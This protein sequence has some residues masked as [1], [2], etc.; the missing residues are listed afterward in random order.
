LLLSD[1]ASAGSVAEARHDWGLCQPIYIQYGRF[2]ANII[3]GDLGMSFKYADPVI[4]LIGERLP[5]PIELAIASML[6]ALLAGIPLGV[7]A[8]AK[9]KSWADNFGSTFGFFGRSMPSCW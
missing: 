2:L 7:W 9:P 3:S 5:A 4:S 6:I 8:G 1:E